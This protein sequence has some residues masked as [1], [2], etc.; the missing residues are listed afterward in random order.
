M[1]K[2]F[3]EQDQLRFAAAVGTMLEVQLAAAGKAGLPAGSERRALGYIYGFVDAAL[4]TI[5]QDMG[6][7][8]L[9]V[10]V[11]FQVLRR[12]FPGREPEYLDLLHE[13][14]GTDRVVIAEM[15]HG[16]QQYLDFNNGKLAAPMGL[17]RI[18][19]SARPAESRPA[20]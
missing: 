19:L 13:A 11:M 4:R 7:P 5:G 12:L 20:T 15:M 6:D 9:G 10:P 18:L 2:P 1:T 3:G 16:G 17:A 8:L 14:M